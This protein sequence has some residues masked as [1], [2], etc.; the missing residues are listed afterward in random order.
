MKKLAILM[1]VSL[2]LTHVNAK[3]IISEETTKTTDTRTKIDPSTTARFTASH[4]IG[5]LSKV[6]VTNTT[7]RG[8]GG[9]EGTAVYFGGGD[10]T[11]TTTTTR[12]TTLVESDSTLKEANLTLKE[13]EPI[14]IESTTTT[15]KTTTRS[16]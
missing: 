7:F 2:S 1:L 9:A 10:R 16:L 6:G 8:I 11:T 14:K 3:E 5:Y 12:E 13:A 4:A 15:T